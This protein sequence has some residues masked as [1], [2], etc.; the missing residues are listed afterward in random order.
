MGRCE[1][2]TLGGRC[3]QRDAKSAPR[4]VAPWTT[5]PQKWWTARGTT[6]GWTSGASGCSRTSF[7]MAWRRLRPQVVAQRMRAFAQWTCA[8]PRNPRCALSM[9]WL[10]FVASGP[11]GRLP[12]CRDIV[13]GSKW[14][15]IVYAHLLSR[16]ALSVC[17]HH[18]V[19]GNRYHVMT[20]HGLLI[21]SLL[22]ACRTDRGC[23]ARAKDHEGLCSNDTGNGLAHL[24][25]PLCNCASPRNHRVP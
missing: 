4:C 7:C 6:R 5:C 20:I 3:T 9:H 22:V 23:G 21:G 15:C 13:Q 19:H 8:S 14:Q 1:S 25:P 16:P 10:L 12:A 24:S 17:I 11:A 18:A 2:R